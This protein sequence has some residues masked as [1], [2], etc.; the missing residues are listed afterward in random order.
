MRKNDSLCRLGGE[1]F[2][3]LL[4][5]TPEGEAAVAAE[6]IRRLI[7]NQIFTTGDK[8]VHLTASFG[9]AQLDYDLDPRLISQYSKADHALYI[10]KQNGRNQVI[11]V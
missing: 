1:E 7:E 3:M 2:I 5:D 8:A 11:A 6:K 9:I 10:A 4:P